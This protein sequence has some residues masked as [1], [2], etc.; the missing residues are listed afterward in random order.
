MC[1][2]WPSRSRTPSS[3]RPASG[4]NTPSH[5]MR[6]RADSPH[7]VAGSPN[8]SAGCHTCR[9]T[10]R[11]GAGSLPLAFET[12]RHV[13]IHVAKHVAQDSYVDGTQPEHG[14]G[15]P[16]HRCI[17]R[18]AVAYGRLSWPTSGTPLQAYKSFRDRN[19]GKLA[20]QYLEGFPIGPVKDHEDGS[21][22]A[23]STYDASVLAWEGVD[24]S[25]AL[26][27]EPGHKPMPPERVEVAREP[28]R[29]PTGT[30]SG[31]GLARS[32]RRKGSE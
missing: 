22:G 11:Q 12:L 17:A 16:L 19:A 14:F 24:A 23:G 30:G 20:S 18:T 29:R 6:E 27:S 5:T 3:Y 13:A 15:S 2:G 28:S 1:N 25:Y 10:C 21:G 32:E 31:L 4:L 26:K 8:S 9:Q 7:V